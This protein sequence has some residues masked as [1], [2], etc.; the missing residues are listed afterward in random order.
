MPPNES[1]AD[2][3]ALH[4]APPTVRRVVTTTTTTTLTFPP[5]LIPRPKSPQ[6]VEP[7]DK[8]KYPL[9]QAETPWNLRRFR[10]EQLDAD[11]SEG[12][13]RGL[14]YDRVV[15]SLP[16]AL[17]SANDFPTQ[18]PSRIRSR[19]EAEVVLPTPDVSSA[20]LPAFRLP[21]SLSQESTSVNRNR[22]SSS[23]V[24]AVVRRRKR[25]N[26]NTQLSDG[27][28]PRKRQR[29]SSPIQLPD[30]HAS[31]ISIGAGPRG[32]S[33]ELILPSPKMSPPSPVETS[34][35]DDGEDEAETKGNSSRQLSLP[36]MDSGFFEEGFSRYFEQSKGSGLQ[37]SPDGALSL[38]PEHAAGLQAMMS[39]PSL[40]NSF[41][42]LAP[43]MQTYVLF[44]LLKRS[45]VSVLQN[46][47]AIITP[48][49]RRDFLTDLPPELAV[50]VLS[51]LDANS[52]C[53]AAQVSKTW[54]KMIDGEWRVWR[55]RLRADGLWQGLGDEEAE[56]NDEGSGL[57]GGNERKKKR[58]DKEFLR[59]W[60]SGIWDDIPGDESEFGDEDRVA[61][62]KKVDYLLARRSN[63]RKCELIKRIANASKRPLPQFNIHYV[64]PYKLL[65]RRRFVSRRNW[66]DREPGR[67]GFQGH[68]I[69]VI[70]CL[71][72]DE[73][74]IVSAS[75]DHNINVYDTKTGELSKSLVGHEGGVWALEYI[76][77]TLVSGSTDR[78]VRVWNLET[79]KNTHVF[80]GHTSTVR[81][82]QIVRPV[83]VQHDPN[84]P[85]VWEPP[86][87]IIVTGSRDYTL[88]MWKLPGINDDWYIPDIPDSPN[89]ENV[90]FEENPFHIR[91]LKGHHHA[92]R[93]LAAKGRTLVSGSYDYDCRVWDIMTGECIRVLKG[94][95]QKVYSIV[96][97]D[98]AKMCM[99][100]SM[101]GTVRVWDI[102]TGEVAHILEGHSS[103]VG[104][105]G[106][107]KHLLVS[108]AA[109]ST[110]RLWR[111]HSGQHLQ[112]LAAHSGAITCFK[113]D[114]MKVVS[115]SDGVLKLWDIKGGR[116]PKDLLTNL[117]GVWQVGFDDRFCVA[118]V[119]RN[120]RSE[121]EILDFGKEIDEMYEDEKF[122]EEPDPF[123]FVGKD[124][125]ARIA[126]KDDADR[127]NLAE[128]RRRRRISSGDNFELDWMSAEGGKG[129]QTLLRRME[130]LSNDIEM[131]R[132]G[133]PLHGEGDEEE[134]EI[135]E[136][137]DE[138]DADNPPI[139]EEEPEGFEENHEEDDDMYVIKEEED[140]GDED[141][142]YDEV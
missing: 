141:E 85:P 81:C 17:T 35:D 39:L 50:L 3:S 97:D 72:F 132:R 68:A 40:V 137:E 91:L 53:R 37:L 89:A 65:Y 67:M 108:A 55:D 43:Q 42:T 118:A 88:R 11:G 25:Q 142:F 138:F 94:H 120:G 136:E 66:M 5:L 44:S 60:F 116:E 36:Q 92:V 112:T 29:Q 64:H 34:Y 70:T 113:H 130:M 102:D 90:H 80:L 79:E 63:E 123:E 114:D 101:D 131:W 106:L 22:R 15:P 10:M 56:V 93:A 46:L 107:S 62:A 125:P 119:Q 57:G 28:P 8:K 121:F 16:S 75:D 51:H 78:T 23:A 1:S 47:H 24:P 109:D 48:A 82:L 20:N 83:N 31:G 99:S 71:Q 27:P 139:K 115:G 61:R 33:T 122:E 69:N 134:R 117:A 49:L 140:Y 111:P 12:G 103:L 105:L 100:G 74:R 32:G 30:P 87:P 73:H 14:V 26:S 127:M 19:D 58:A 76:G 54:A 110:L 13:T 86:Y 45:P 104:L 126:W 133:G 135:K 129:S 52:L 95:T 41:S 124:E 9:S 4:L 18:P 38:R 21:T 84:G 2:Y 77:N 128:K 6:H 96:L 59:M 7:L 98:E